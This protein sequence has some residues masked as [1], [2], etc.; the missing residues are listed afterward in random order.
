MPTTGRT[1]LAAS[2]ALAAPLFVGVCAAQAQGT[3]PA[4]TTGAA[5]SADTTAMMR[6]DSATMARDTMRAMVPQLDQAR[7]VDAEIRMALFELQNDRHVPALS[8]LEWLQSSPTALT[9]AGT[10]D[11]VG[12][13]RGRQQLLFLLAE[14]Y[15]RLGMDDAFRTTATTL[16]QGTGGSGGRYA[17]V[18]RSQLLLDAYRRGDYAA[19]VQMA[20][21]LAEGAGDRGLAQ[22][23]AGLA[24]YQTGRYAEARTSF[25]VATQAG[26][27]Y[28]AYAQYMDALAML[29]ADTAQTAPALQ[30]LQAVASS[31][32]GEF[33]DQV[34]LTAAQL[35][36]ES[37]RYADAASI[38]GQVSMTGGLASQAMLTRAWALYKSGQVAPA[39]DAFAEF[40]RRFPQLPERD[41]A[42]LMSA[43]A[44]LQLGR[45]AE[46]GTMFR[47]VADSVKAEAGMMEA[48]AQAALREA[49]GA[50]VQARAAALLFLTD[51]AS[52]KTVALQDGAGVN[53]AVLAAA[54]TDSMIAVLPTVGAPEIVSLEDVSVRL[55]SLSGMNAA[56]R[57]LLFSTASAATNRAEYG[58]RAQALY[59]AD[60]RVAL[61]RF[62]LQEQLAAQARQLATLRA[63]QAQLEGANSELAPLAARLTAARDSLARVAAVLDVA[64]QR[65]T[66][67]FQTQIA[68]TRTLA[69]ENAALL[70]SVRTSL[71]ATMTTKDGEVLAI[72]AR[73]AAT[74][75]AF[76]D[77][78]ERGLGGAITRHPAFALRDSV[79]MRGDRIGQLLGET[80]AALASA[81]SALD[82]EL[83][84]VQNGETER[85]R[86]MRTMLATAESRRASA[87]TGLVAVVERELR[88]RAGEMLADLRRDT[89][90]AEFGSAS[91][92]FFMALDA[93][94]TMPAGGATT[95]ATTGSTTGVAPQ[96]A[97]SVPNGGSTAGAQPAAPANATT[98]PRK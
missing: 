38:A 84:R 33:A 19:A 24:H 2:I 3:P 63:L 28:A 86:M 50:L 98:L 85:T 32:S 44:L 57:R 76:A 47:L 67:L 7:G 48:N 34:R 45:T 74:Y 37:E 15:Y 1:I 97:A 54:V 25:A 5:G 18:L 40:A 82:E 23:V 62:Q 88:A 27:P 61:A 22:L 94:T 65:L 43:Q 16:M 8:R 89:E 36:Y 21:T 20:S 68:A 93:S 46:A 13:L 26:A 91:A 77:D 12:A 17:G 70:D 79:R 66:A 11:G 52:G 75:R 31:A 71:G 55:D 92:S 49:A 73:T 6:R 90:A 14:S 95:G 59:D 39:G 29:R 69:A 64:G 60:V 41:E 42:R 78:I 96:G 30:A 80:Q 51:P 35:A 87:E 10:G 56:P 58:T 72:E 53:A 81:R 83:G 9:G 4:T